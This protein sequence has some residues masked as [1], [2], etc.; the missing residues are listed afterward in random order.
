MIHS[1]LDYQDTPKRYS[2][3]KQV[4]YICLACMLFSAHFEYYL[5]VYKNVVHLCTP[6]FVLSLLTYFSCLNFKIY[7]KYCHLLILPTDVAH[8]YV[9]VQ[10]SRLE[11]EQELKNI[12]IICTLPMVSWISV[13]LKSSHPV[14]N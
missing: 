11:T 2:Y 1:L 4:I 6:I 14:C 3:L 8:Y 12:F 13:P 7:D 9:L 5:T 10:H